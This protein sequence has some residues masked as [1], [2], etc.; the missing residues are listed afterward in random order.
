MC[1]FSD[2]LNTIIKKRELSQTEAAKLCGIAQQS[3]NYIIN[4]KLK[5]SKLAPQI[6]EALNINPEWLIY[7]T[8][9][10]ELSKLYDL[11]I[12][13]SA[14]MLKKLMNRELDLKTL[15]TTVID[16]F[17]GHG[18]FAY[19]T[20]PNEMAIC[21]ESSQKESVSTKEFLTLSN[22]DMVII[23]VKKEKL[24]FPIFEWRRRYEDF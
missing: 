2:R 23:T 10:P 9:K 15:E 19:L 1:N 7:G 6:A 14:Y 4:S 20:K 8:G 18:A 11:P 17:L 22:E 24:S 21:G 13:H 3:L 12:I 5:S 16:K